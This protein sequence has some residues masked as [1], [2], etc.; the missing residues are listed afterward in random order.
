MATVRLV[1][2]LLREHRKLPLYDLQCGSHSV[3]QTFAS[4]PRSCSR[5]EPCAL[6]CGDLYE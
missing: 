4:E 6:G 3:A 2:V 5:I 1:G